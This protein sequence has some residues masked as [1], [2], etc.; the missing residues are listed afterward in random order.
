MRIQIAW[1]DGG[2][3]DL[4]TGYATDAL[5]STRLMPRSDGVYVKLPNTQTVSIIELLGGATIEECMSSTFEH[6][7]GQHVDAGESYPA[8]ALH[9]D[10]PFR[11]EVDGEAV[12]TWPVALGDEGGRRLLTPAEA[13]VLA[14]PAR[15]RD[16]D[17]WLVDVSGEPG[18]D[19]AG[20]DEVPQE[21]QAPEPAAGGAGDEPYFDDDELAEMLEPG[22]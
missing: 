15:W 16:L 13:Y 6:F 17:S 4:D 19:E 2:V 1:G 7:V 22:V 20:D 5:G 11:F 14:N 3:T 12:W 10:V 9:G 18:G 8:A 21:G